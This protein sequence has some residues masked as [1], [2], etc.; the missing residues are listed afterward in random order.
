MAF[1]FR[2]VDAGGFPEIKFLDVRAGVIAARDERRSL[3]FDGLQRP[4]DIAHA[5]DADR[6]AIRTDQDEVVVHDWIA[7]DAESIGD[8][9]LLLRLGMHEHDIGIASPASIERLPRALR[10]DTHV[11]AGPRLEHWKD[12]TEQP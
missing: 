8:E 11:D 3:G 10:H 2:D 5:L 4:R 9:L 7:L 1:L 6:I 12:V